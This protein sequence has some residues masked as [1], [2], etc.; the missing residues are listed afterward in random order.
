MAAK[1][2]MIQEM[3]RALQLD[4]KCNEGEQCR[5]GQC[6]RHREAKQQFEKYA[7]IIKGT[8]EGQQPI[9]FKVCV[10]SAFDKVFVGGYDG[11]EAAYKKCTQSTHALWSMLRTTKQNRRQGGTP[12]LQQLKRLAEYFRRHVVGEGGAKLKLVCVSV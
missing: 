12:Q 5:C 4:V 11:T 3:Q 8:E 1:A 9:E 10:C 2:M 6:Q 7:A